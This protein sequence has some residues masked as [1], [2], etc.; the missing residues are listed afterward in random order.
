MVET[1]YVD[2]FSDFM[3]KIS[4]LEKKQTKILYVYFTGKKDGNG[5]SWCPDCNDGKPFKFH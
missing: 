3:N 1:F 4:N 2:G 5:K